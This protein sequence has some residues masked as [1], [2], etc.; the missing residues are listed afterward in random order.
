[1]FKFSQ[2]SIKNLDGV[3]PDLIAVC[4]LALKLTTVDFVIIEGVRNRR[5]QEQ[6]VLSGASQTMNSRHL[7]GHAIDVAAWA[8]GAISWA[9]P[10]YHLIAE[11]F[12][13]A[14]KELEIDIVWGGDWETFKDGPHFQ[15]S[16]T[17]YPAI[18]EKSAPTPKRKKVS[19]KTTAKKIAAVKPCKTEQH[20]EQRT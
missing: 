10:H 12:K 1:M 8:D 6:L 15:L 16:H 17:V 19:K 9:W 4:T 3:H 5:R 2:R 13:R 18:G 14:A 20:S 11:A 7:T